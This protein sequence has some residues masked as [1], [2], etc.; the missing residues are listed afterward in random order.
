[1]RYLTTILLSA[2]MLTACGGSDDNRSF[3]T[4]YMLSPDPDTIDLDDEVNGF[5]GARCNTN[6]DFWYQVAVYDLDSSNTHSKWTLLFRAPSNITGTVTASSGSQPTFRL[7]SNYQMQ[8]DGSN[9]NCLT[10]D[11]HERI[12]RA[13][14]G[15]V[16]FD[17]VEDANFQLTFEE[18]SS[19]NGPP[20]DDNPQLVTV[21]GCWR[22]SNSR[23]SCWDGST[24]DDEEDEGDEDETP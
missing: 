21:S 7:L 9:S 16:N 17:S 23:T 11:D 12:F 8:S 15:Y 5:G 20:I 1:M 6:E 2:A 18:R 10:H 22:V 14:S 13:V 24:A 3:L 19:F 4:G